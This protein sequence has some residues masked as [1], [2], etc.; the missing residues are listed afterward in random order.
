MQQVSWLH[1]GAGLL[2]QEIAQLWSPVPG[3]LES[4][5]QDA[6]L[7]LQRL[8]HSLCTSKAHGSTGLPSL[9]SLGDTDLVHMPHLH[10]LRLSGDPLLLQLL[11]QPDQARDAQCVSL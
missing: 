5:G 2:V 8:F 7:I 6:I 1:V 11:S 4:N 9:F 3:C 10:F